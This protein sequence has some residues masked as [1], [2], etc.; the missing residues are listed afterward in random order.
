MD[1]NVNRKKL[2]CRNKNRHVDYMRECD[3][4]ITGEI[5][6]YKGMNAVIKY[7]DIFDRNNEIFIWEM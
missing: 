7:N 3:L 2:P 4:S 1:L 5:I 6:R